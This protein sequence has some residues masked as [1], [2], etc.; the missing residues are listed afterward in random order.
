MISLTFFFA[1]LPV[2][3]LCLY[4]IFQIEKK[5]KKKTKNKKQKQ[6]K[7]KKNQNK[8]WQNDFINFLFF[9]GFCLPVFVLCLVCQMLTVSL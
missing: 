8:T 5:N 4:S 7:K 6:S 1:F 2:F 3:V 9:G